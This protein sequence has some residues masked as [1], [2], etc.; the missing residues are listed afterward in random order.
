MITREQA[1]VELKGMRKVIADAYYRN[2]A[3]GE[4]ANS[5]IETALDALQYAV[6]E[7]DH[8]TEKGGVE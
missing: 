1:I 3:Y 7:L 4:M 8:P 5:F 6:D 2:L